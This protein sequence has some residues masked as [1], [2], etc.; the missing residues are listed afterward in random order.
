LELHADADMTAIIPD[1]VAL[2]NEEVGREKILS[3]HGNSSLSEHPP[4]GRYLPSP[5][6]ETLLVFGI[7]AQA[8][9]TDA[10]AIFA[11]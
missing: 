6:L 5:L 3:S 7:F 10:G 9:D 1:I 8:I 4:S 11:F 2:D